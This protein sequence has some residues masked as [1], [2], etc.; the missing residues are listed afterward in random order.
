MGINAP[1][2]AR[3][4][5]VFGLILAASSGLRSAR[6]LRGEEALTEEQMCS[7]A[8]SIFAESNH[9]GRSA[10][11]SHIL[12]IEVIR[13]LRQEGLAPFMIA[14]T[15]SRLDGRSE[16]A[17]HMIR[18]RHSE[19][20]TSG[21]EVNELVL[22]NSHDGACSFR[23]LAGVHSFDCSNDLVVGGVF[24]GNRVPHKGDVRQAII[25]SALRIL[26]G[27][28]DVDVSI[29]WMKALE[30]DTS[31]ELA[32]AE[33]ALELRYGKRGEGQPPVPISALQLAEARRPES[34]GTS[35]W[36]A[37]QRIQENALRG[38]QAGRTTNGRGFLTRGVSGIERSVKL[39]QALWSLAERVGRAMC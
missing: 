3:S 7:A 10:R 37:F 34:H 26:D 1:A 12:T 32:F 29:R 14:R 5:G 17:G 13:D 27:F 31:T 25:E 18:L 15:P 20:A 4:E 16:H 22:I 24:G 36:Q 6:A 21:S 23:T 9:A 39:N 19:R 35:L 11:Y 30:I 38:G 28:R 33:A 2:G 8:P